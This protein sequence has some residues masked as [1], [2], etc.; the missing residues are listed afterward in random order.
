VSYVEPWSR[1]SFFLIARLVVQYAFLGTGCG[2]AL[3]APQLSLAPEVEIEDQV[4][5][6]DAR[7]DTE[8]RALVEELKREVE[9]L[10]LSHSRLAAGTSA[11]SQSNDAPATDTNES[12]SSGFF[13]TYDNRWVIRPRDPQK[14]PFEFGVNFFNQ[15]RHT[16]IDAKQE[17]FTDSAGVSRPIF[18]RSTF[19]INR[20]FI[21]FSGYAID[22]KLRYFTL[23]DFNTLARPQLQL[24]IG[25]CAYQFSEALTIHAGMGQMPGTWEWLVASRYVLG[26][27]RTMAT[28]FFR[29][30]LT[31]GIWATGR[32]RDS[33]NYRI[34]VGDGFNSF[35]VTPDQR[36]DNLAYSAMMWWEPLGAYGRPHTDFEDRQTPAVRL[37]HALTFAD[38]A[39]D[40]LTGQPGPEQ[41]IVRLSD[42]TVLVS[43]NALAPD[44]QV[45]AFDILLYAP[46]LGMKY[47]GMSFAGEYFFRWLSSISGTGP[48]PVSSL[49]DHGFMVNA[50]TFLLPKRLE[51]YAL[52]SRVSGD[53]GS[54]SEVAAGVNY[55]VKQRENSKFT[56]EFAY[57]DSSPAEQARTGLVAGLTGPMIRTQYWLSF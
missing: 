29:P 54:G 35:G 7:K 49:F 52:G 39:A 51:V 21:V 38:K 4:S 14:T 32:L 27:E 55:Y 53:F 48:L 5:G 34:M 43:P 3:A 47:R 2:L 44:T 41:S 12:D 9:M 26:I 16:E 19:D 13:V 6:V 42:G 28:T 30:S 40:R 45:N 56:L 33:L 31:G 20:G 50:G 18:D 8:L 37:G 46:H 1:R 11:G 10:K 24:I 36:D 17:V 22:P 25:W 57:I 15:F 23:V